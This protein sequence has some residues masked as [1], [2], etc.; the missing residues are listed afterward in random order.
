MQ[1]K[2]SLLQS[3]QNET[4]NGTDNE[5]TS[6]AEDTIEKGIKH[7]IPS[8]K[9]KK[10]IPKP[11]PI[12]G[13]VEIKEG[14][15]YN[16]NE[17]ML[18]STEWRNTITKKNKLPVI[19]EIKVRKGINLP[20]SNWLFKSPDRKNINAQNNRLIPNAINRIYCER[21]KKKRNAKPI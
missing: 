7:C 21:R 18:L 2:T 20:N 3:E 12:V 11:K 13:K 14:R 15:K 19:N 6:L 8:F 17:V 16:S 1:V 4:V 10:S 9:I 5:R